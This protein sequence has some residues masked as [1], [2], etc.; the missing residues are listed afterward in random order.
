MTHTAAP[1]S[2][3]RRTDE[4]PLDTVL[5]SQMNWFTQMVEL[6]STWFTSCLVLQGDYWRYWMPES[7]ELP[8]WM[9]WH[10]G[11]EQLA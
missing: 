4:P 3:D 8:A 1:A 9:V 5:Q 10:N 11:T 7:L 6:Q 2:S